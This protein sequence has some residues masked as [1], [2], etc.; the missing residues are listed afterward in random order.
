MSSP[1]RRGF[2]LILTAAVVFYSTSTARAQYPNYVLET[3]SPT[4]SVKEPI[5]N[6]FVNA[7]NGNLHIEIPL[8][9]LPQRGGQAYVA[10]LVYD[11]RI[12]KPVSNGAATVW[13]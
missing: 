4:F 12:W 8:V 13:Q 1:Y 3:G 10:K 11:S 6:G 7:A 5:P 9:S 2:D